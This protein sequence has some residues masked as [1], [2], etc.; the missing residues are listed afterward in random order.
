MEFWMVLDLGYG[1]VFGEMGRRSDGD[2]YMRE[3]CTM[4]KALLRY[5][6][7]L[8]GHLEQKG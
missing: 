7:G 8:F 1:C 5:E 2:R 4:L 6:Y 3:G